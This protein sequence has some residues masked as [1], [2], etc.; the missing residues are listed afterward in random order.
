MVQTSKKKP[1]AKWIIQMKIPPVLAGAGDLDVGEVE[2]AL[3]EAQ[4]EECNGVSGVVINPGRRG[5]AS[6]PFSLE[7]YHFQ[8]IK[9]VYFPSDDGEK[10]FS[11][12]SE[13]G[14]I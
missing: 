13:P 7:M 9:Q 6:S 5:L 3:D 2:E 10:L 11:V 4:E 14:C 8:I 1:L 12:R